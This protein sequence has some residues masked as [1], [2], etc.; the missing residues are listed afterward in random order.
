VFPVSGCSNPVS[1]MPMS[2]ECLRNACPR[3]HNSQHL[4][5]SLDEFSQDSVADRKTR[6][7]SYRFNVP[8]SLRQNRNRTSERVAVQ[9]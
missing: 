3:R 5:L 8:I 4:S 1:I 9:Y 6:P 7:E 2:H